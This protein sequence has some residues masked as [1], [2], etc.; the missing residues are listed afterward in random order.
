MSRVNDIMFSVLEFGQFKNYFAEATLYKKSIH[1]FN[2][3]TLEKKEFDFSSLKG[4]KC[5]IVNTASACGL[6]P[7]YEDLQELYDTHKHKGFEIIAFPCNDFAAQEK[8]SNA[9]IQSF[10][11]RN[12]GVT[13]TVMD[14]VHVKGSDIHPIFTWLTRKSE[15]G[16][17]SSVIK[18]NFQKFMMDEAGQLV[19]VLNPWT[20]PDCKKIQNW[21]N[22]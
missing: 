3:L 13:F 17:M 20:K 2:A 5:L 21:L 16:V 8:G 1:S 22:Q 14:K 12:Y 6:T 9:E 10:C 7:Q 15:N 11:Q 4:K 19:D 18:W